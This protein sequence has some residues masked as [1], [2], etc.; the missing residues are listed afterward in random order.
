MYDTTVTDAGPAVDADALG[1]RPRFAPAWAVGVAAATVADATRIGWTRTVAGEGPVSFLAVGPGLVQLGCADL[2]KSQ[3]RA[4]RAVRA[5]AHLMEAVRASGAIAAETAAH[6]SL[7]NAGL[8]DKDDYPVYDDPEIE[9]PFDPLER[10]PSGR[11]VTAWSRKSRANMVR[12]LS[13]LDYEPMV[14]QGT[15]AMVTLTLPENW[16]AYAPNGKAFKRLLSRWLDR[17]AR[18]WGERLRGLWKLEFQRRGAPHLHILT[19][20]RQG[21]DRTYG[22]R[23]RDWV[24][25]SWAD[26]VVGDASHPDFEPVRWLHSRRKAACDYAE[27]LRASDPKR[28]G[29]YFL[30]HNTAGDKEYQHDVPVEWRGAGDGPGRF[31]GYWRLGVVLGLVPITDQQRRELHRLLRR[32][33]TAKRGTRRVKAPRVNTRTGEVRMRSVRRRCRPLPSWEGMP[34]GRG[35]LVVNDGPAVAL[36]I[37]S[38]LQGGRADPIPYS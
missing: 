5:H 32:W 2:A 3:R 26:V 37:A 23:W 27:G 4:E 16:L 33:E 29:V 18:A 36:L 19:V 38:Y 20:P 12:R 25:R 34:P 15:P 6:W 17:Y 31:W 22:L 35:Y 10:R 14:A 21:T 8:L 11:E 24:G 28:I 1:Y 9:P 30:K 7:W 13:T